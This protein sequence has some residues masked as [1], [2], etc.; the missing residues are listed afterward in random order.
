MVQAGLPR[1]GTDWH[2]LRLDVQGDR[3]RVYLDGALVADHIDVGFDG[4]P[5]YG[6]GGVSIDTWTQS[7][8]SDSIA[9]QVDE[10]SVWTPNEYPQLGTLRSSAYFGGPRVNWTTLAWNAVLS[11]ATGVRVRTR[12][13]DDPTELQDAVWSPWLLEGGSTVTSQDRSWI[14]YEVELDSTD[15]SET[16]ELLELT[17]SFY[18]TP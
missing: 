4:R 5:P 6:T 14:Q 17:T 18:G 10:V 13:A 8:D 7:S 1:L 9:I 15:P 3:V 12:T 16:P 11:D 2:D